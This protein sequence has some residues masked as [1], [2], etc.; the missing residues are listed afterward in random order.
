MYT[1]LKTIHVASAILTISGFALRAYWSLAKPGKLR[2]RAV[3]TLPHVVDT[4]F[5]LSGIGL[6]VVMHLNALQQDWL[7][8][9]F[10]ALILYI[11]LGMLALRQQLGRGI[12][13]SAF[14]A[15]L[16]TFAYIVGAALLKTP[17]SWLNL[18]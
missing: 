18:I 3:R 7:L 6:I 14:V 4:I 11:A 15:A 13:Y 10:A 1:T 12:R 2:S 16:A 17:Y 9:K 5:L 8:A